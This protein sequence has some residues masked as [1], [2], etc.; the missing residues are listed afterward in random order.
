MSVVNFWT[1]SALHLSVSL[2]LC[3]SVSLCIV[4]S[5]PLSLS[6]SLCLSLCRVCSVCNY[7]T[8]TTS[9][10]NVLTSYVLTWF[11]ATRLNHVFDMNHLLQHDS[12]LCA[13]WLRKR[14]LHF[15]RTYWLDLLHAPAL[16]DVGYVL[17]F[18]CVWHDSFIC[19][20]QLL[21]V[22]DMTH[23]SRTSWCA[24]WPVIHVCVT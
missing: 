2:S 19:A 20:T 18:I 17:S 13:T 8:T 10:M 21:D 23:W 14:Q 16:H 1:W 11:A 15:P 7:W 4:C 6:L 24:L 3:F 12:F 22:Y 9:F 5:L